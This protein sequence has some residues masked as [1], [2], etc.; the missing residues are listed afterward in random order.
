MLVHMACGSQRPVVGRA[1]MLP[2][3]HAQSRVH[4]GPE[5]DQHGVRPGNPQGPCDAEM[6]VNQAAQD[7][8]LSPFSKRAEQELRGA[9]SQCTVGEV[10][11]FVDGGQAELRDQ[12]MQQLRG[13]SS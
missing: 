8:E 10:P 5:P 11:H 1:P 9:G 6:R 12:A 13:G 3:P 4:G 7:A 2:L